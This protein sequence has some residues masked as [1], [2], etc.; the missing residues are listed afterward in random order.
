MNPLKFVLV[1]L[2]FPAI[3]CSSLNAS[4]DSEKMDGMRSK[5]HE[6]MEAR[7]QELFKDLG[8]NDQQKK[9]LEDNKDKNRGQSKAMRQSMH[10]KMTQLRQELQKDTLDMGKINQIQGELKALQG[11]LLDQRLAGILEVRKILTPEQFKTFSEKME[12]HRKA[13]GEHW[14]HDQKEHSKDGDVSEPHE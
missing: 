12:E 5:W 9:A 13:D 1:A 8:L 11:Q 10:E 2:V 4:A 14:E 3:L 7:H 6:K